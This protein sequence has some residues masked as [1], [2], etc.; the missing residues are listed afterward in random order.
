M[1][2]T[3]GLL[4]YGIV[5]TACP[6]LRPPLQPVERATQYLNNCLTIVGHAYSQPPSRDVREDLEN[7]TNQCQ[8]ALNLYDGI[9]AASGFPEDER[10]RQRPKWRLTKFVL[11]HLERWNTLSVELS[12][13]QHE[14]LAGQWE[15]MRKVWR[16]DL[17][18]LENTSDPDRLNAYDVL[19][20][21]ISEILRIEP[22]DTQLFDEFERESRGML[23][24]L[25]NTNDPEQWL[26]IHDA[27]VRI[28]IYIR[29]HD[30]LT[31]SGLC[32]KL[33]EADLN[34]R[35]PRLLAE[36]RAA[37]RQCSDQ[38]SNATPKELYSRWME[39]YKKWAYQE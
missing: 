23:A 30:W 14:G 27:R 10:R 16:E 34:R 12:K 20:N 4:C 36:A 33:L 5:L 2:T 1:L 9:I 13:G 6:R 19:R 15:E 24:K 29:R 25:A 38:L 39:D 7:A 28:W 17:G 32:R 8:N 26:I 37:A 35:N 11:W 18:L 21:V 31:A 3:L 22:S